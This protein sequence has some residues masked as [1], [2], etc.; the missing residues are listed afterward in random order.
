MKDNEIYNAI[1]QTLTI[2]E[3]NFRYQ[4]GKKI[5]YEEIFEMM[6]DLHILFTNFEENIQECGNLATKRYIPLLDLLV[7]ID[8][9]GNHLIEYNK[10]LKTK[11]RNK[12]INSQARALSGLTVFLSV[13]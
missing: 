10:Q 2:L 9:N 3:N 13:P 1:D 7:S 5:T 12:G 6:K 8:N 4:F 11:I